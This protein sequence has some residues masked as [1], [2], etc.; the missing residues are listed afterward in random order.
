MIEFIAC[1]LL[2]PEPIFM[3]TELNVRFQM[4]LVQRVR[5]WIKKNPDCLLL[6]SNTDCKQIDKL[7]W[8]GAF[9]PFL[10][11]AI[12]GEFNRINE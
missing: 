9:S 2:E 8:I 1:L 7:K 10:C 12:P 6:H 3:V 4:Y 5:S 11:A